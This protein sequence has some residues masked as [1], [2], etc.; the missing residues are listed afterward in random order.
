MKIRDADILI[1]PGLGNASP[2]HWQS[3][4]LAKMPTARRV[5]QSNWDHPVCSAWTAGVNVAIAAATKPVILV[6]HS[7]GVLTVAHAAGDWNPDKIAGAF[8]VGPSDWDR[9]EMENKYP[10]HGFSPVREK[11]LGCPAVVLASTNDP[12]CTP[13]T[14]ERWAKAWSAQ[15]AI[16][17][18]VGHFDESDGFGP[19]PEGLLAFARFMKSL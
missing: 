9:P 15:F 18:E 7:V 4:W 2:L 1:V 17:G 3:R 10:G 11:P 12:T 14:A 5:E 8:L 16:A 6:A 19:W 13:E